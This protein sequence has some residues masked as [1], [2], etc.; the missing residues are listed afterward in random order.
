MKLRLL[1]AACGA[2]LLVGG[3]I[4]A[5]AS[6]VVISSTDLTPTDGEATFNATNLDAEQ[7]DIVLGDTGIAGCRPSVNPMAL[8]PSSGVAAG[9]TKITIMLNGCDLANGL[10]LPITFGDAEPTSFSIKAPAVT[11]VD[12]EAL[13]DWFV[14]ASFLAAAVVGFAAGIRFILNIGEPSP[15]SETGPRYARWPGFRPLYGIDAGWKFK[16]SWV[17]N[18][19]VFTSG[20]AVLVASND[21]M[22]T[23]LGQGADKRLGTI[24]VGSAIAA[25]L[26]AVSPIGVLLSRELVGG[27]KNITQWGLAL[28]AWVTLT[29]TIGEVFLLRSEGLEL[30]DGWISSSI[31]AAGIVGFIAICLYSG[32]SLV[33]LLGL[34]NPPKPDPNAEKIADLLTQLIERIKQQ[35][36]TM[37]VRPGSEQEDAAEELATLRESVLTPATTQT[38]QPA[39]ASSL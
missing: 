34:T 38:P 15:N 8:P 25:M 26:V 29:G 9:P 5:A 11:A 4:A 35:P 21:A 1:L 27:G 20:L 14:N 10:A 6:S 7:V 31:G 19:T 37:G 22:K 39:R 12:S 13:K 16:D 17:S 30:T 23:L 36:D 2:G 24:V 32:A 3:G 28:G 33:R 18:V